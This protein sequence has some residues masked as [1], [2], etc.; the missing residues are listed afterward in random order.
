MKLSKNP[1]STN[2]LGPF[3]YLH[4]YIIIDR[5]Y[6]NLILQQWRVL[7]GAVSSF[8]FLWDTNAKYRYIRVKCMLKRRRSNFSSDSSTRILTFFVA[9][10]NS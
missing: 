5:D 4:V 9:I 6:K 7:D 10:S 8:A 2:Q 3:D 1:R